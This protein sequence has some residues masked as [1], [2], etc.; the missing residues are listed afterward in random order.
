M[1]CLFLWYGMITL[2]IEM[3][4]F[5]PDSVMLK[6]SFGSAHGPFLVNNC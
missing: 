2:L 3:G 6:S 5:N 1:G 4:G